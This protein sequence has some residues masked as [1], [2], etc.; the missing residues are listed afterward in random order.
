MSTYPGSYAVPGSMQPGSI[1][2][3]DALGAGG[4]EFTIFTGNVPLTYLQYLDLQTGHTL[5]VQ[6]GHEY[7]VTPAS[8]YPYPLAV[9]PGDGRWQGGGGDEMMMATFR[10]A[11][12]VLAA[13][14]A[15]NARLHARLARGEK[16][17][18]LVARI[19]R[20]EE[21]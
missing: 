4:E 13:G 3:G 16:I 21:I 18:D 6:P 7:A 5:V 1:W 17:A 2:P 12:E 14:R 10:P 11:A 19:E 9:P 8:G 20:G 15:H